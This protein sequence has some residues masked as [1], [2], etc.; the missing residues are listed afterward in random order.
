VTTGA[1][2][3]YAVTRAGTWRVYDDRIT[4]TPPRP[5]TGWTATQPMPFIN[6][7]RNSNTLPAGRPSLARRL[8]ARAYCGP[9]NPWPCIMMNLQSNDPR[10]NASRRSS[11]LYIDSI[12]F[13]RNPRAPVQSRCWPRARRPALAAPMPGGTN[14]AANKHVEGMHHLVGVTLSP[15]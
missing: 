13:L 14:A 9:E 10:R 7:I 12:A 4:A 15:A 8:S 11:K 6:G 2:P 3:A 5:L 1:H